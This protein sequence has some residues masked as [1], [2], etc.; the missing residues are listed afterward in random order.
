LGILLAIKKGLEKL[1]IKGASKENVWVACLVAF[2][3]AFRLGKI[4]AKGKRQFNIFS[5]L[6][7]QEV[8]FDQTETKFSFKIKSV[9]IPGS[10]GNLAEIFVVRDRVFCPVLA[11]K[12]LERRQK[13]DGIWRQ[14]APVFRRASGKNL[15]KSVFL[16][17]V[18]RALMAGGME[19]IKI[20]GKSFRAGLLLALNSLP[21]DFQEA[22]LKALGRWKGRSYQFYMWKGPIFFSQTFRAVA[23]TLLRDFECCRCPQAQVVPS[24]GSQQRQ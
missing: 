2:W 16:K 18:N 15:T 20:G 5:D 22:H 13:V 12:R 24:E 9:K 23:D 17:T 10:P 7:W 11:L 19:N 14:D 3:G 6:L 8:T 1:K 21:R 4:L